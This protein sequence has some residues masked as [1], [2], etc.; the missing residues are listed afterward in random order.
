MEIEVAKYD[1]SHFPESHTSFVGPFYFILAVSFSISS[2]PV[3]CFQYLVHLGQ[4]CTFNYQCGT[5]G[6]LA[7]AWFPAVNMAVDYITCHA[8][9]LT[10][11]KKIM[12]V[13]CDEGD[14]VT[15]STQELSHFYCLDEIYLIKTSLPPQYRYF[16]P[17]LSNRFGCR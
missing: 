8:I 15:S 7:A 4:A 2:L 12:R 17:F 14:L 1:P 5:S 9:E 6:T 3:V 13:C 16:I 10:L 11:K